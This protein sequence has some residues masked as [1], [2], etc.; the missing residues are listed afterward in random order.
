VAEAV[1]QLEET[2]KSL[3]PGQIVRFVYTLGHPMVYAWDLPSLPDPRSLDASRYID[4]LLRSE[5]TV[6]TPLE[7]LR[8]QLN[9]RVFDNVQ[10]VPFQTKG[11]S[12]H[13][14]QTLSTL[15]FF[16]CN[17]TATRIESIKNIE[18]RD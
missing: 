13:D 16:Y 3:R 15:L 4:L 6:L 9:E 8:K 11:L 7:I 1:R 18:S 17:L 10:S 12:I 14:K 2:G 5:E